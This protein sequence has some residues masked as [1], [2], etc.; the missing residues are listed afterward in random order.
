[1]TL[2]NAFSNYVALKKLK[3]NIMFEVFHSHCSE[4]FSRFCLPQSK[5]FELARMD[6]D[7]MA[8]ICLD[9]VTMEFHLLMFEVLIK[10]KKAFIIWYL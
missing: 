2:N 9:R 4:V 7:S 10:F 3:E 5:R 1:M 8:L 6:I